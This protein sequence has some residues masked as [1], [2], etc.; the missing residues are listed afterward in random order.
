MGIA[1]YFLLI[2]NPSL[3]YLFCMFDLE[4]KWRAH[5]PCHQRNGHGTDDV[6]YAQ[7]PEISEF[8]TGRRQTNPHPPVSMPDLG[9]VTMTS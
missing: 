1:L 4:H 3:K 9:H 2:A 6:E 7:T 8:E 5:G